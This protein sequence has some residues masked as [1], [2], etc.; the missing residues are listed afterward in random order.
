MAEATLYNDDDMLMLS[1]IQHIAFCERQWAICQ[2]A[3]EA[4]ADD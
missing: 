4:G 2:I 1:G 3:V